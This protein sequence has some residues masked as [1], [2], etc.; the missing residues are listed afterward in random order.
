MN[1]DRIIHIMK[2]W[3]ISLVEKGARAQKSTRQELG[4]LTPSRAR[5]GSYNNPCFI[6][7]KN[8]HC[9]EHQKK[10]NHY[11]VSRGLQGIRASQWGVF[12]FFS[13]LAFS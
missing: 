8:N 10:N 7:K 3:F 4:P 9:F 2:K 11:C 5:T 6:D 1:N 13:L 12:I